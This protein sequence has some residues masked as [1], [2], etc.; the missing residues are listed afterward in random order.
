MFEWGKFLKCHLKGKTFSELANGLNIYD[1]KNGLTPGVILP[2]LWGYIHAYYHSRPT[3][4]LV[5]TSG[6]R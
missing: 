5:Y 6:L 1:L 2:L 4:L 3:S